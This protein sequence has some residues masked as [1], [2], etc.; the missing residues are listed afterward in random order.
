MKKDKSG[1]TLIEL[2]IVIGIIG[3]LASIVMTSLSSA[4]E[5]ANRASAISTLSSIMSEMAMCALDGGGTD[6]VVIGHAICTDGSGSN[7]AVSGHEDALWPDITAKTGWLIT[8]SQA[9]QIDDDY[10]YGAAKSGQ[11]AISCSVRSNS[12]Q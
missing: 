10:V 6:G 4:K 8:A 9:S 3:I 12:C 7:T 11:V 2:L 1:F 5:K